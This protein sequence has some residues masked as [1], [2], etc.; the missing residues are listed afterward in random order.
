MP[1][2]GKAIVMP[3]RTDHKTPDASSADAARLRE[4][5]CTLRAPGDWIKHMANSLKVDSRTIQRWAAG[6]VERGAEVFAALRK[7]AANRCRE[8]DAIVKWD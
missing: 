2:N 3:N 1:R 6:E 8:I 5:G 7:V 4:I